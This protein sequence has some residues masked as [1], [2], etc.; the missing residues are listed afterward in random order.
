MWSRILK[1]PF[2]LLAATSLLMGCNRTSVAYRP[3]STASKNAPRMVDFAI[4]ILDG[5]RGAFSGPAEPTFLGTMVIRASRL[6]SDRW[7]AMNAAMRGATHYTLGSV[8]ST[9]SGSK[10]ICHAFGATAVCQTK[11]LRGEA[12]SFALFRVN[13]DTWDMLPVEMRPPPPEGSWVD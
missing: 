11:N 2:A 12:G 4:E 6:P 9:S 13:K 10:T 5:D 7:V 3:H 1:L 8:E